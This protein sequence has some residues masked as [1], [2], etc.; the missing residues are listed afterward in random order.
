MLLLPLERMRQNPKCH[1]EGD[2]LY[3]S[4]QVF[5]LA[6]DAQPYD[7]EFLLAALFTTSAKE[8]IRTITSRLGLKR[9]TGISR[10]AP[11]G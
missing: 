1:P 7:E 10:R 11:P 3:H 6:C 2:V 5:D 8:S 9:S 4:L